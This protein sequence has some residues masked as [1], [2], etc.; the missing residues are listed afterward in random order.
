VSASFASIEWLPDPGRTPDELLYALDGWAERRELAAAT[1]SRETLGVAL[2]IAREKLAELEAMVAKEDASAAAVARDRYASAIAEAGTAV[3]RGEDREVA[4]LARDLCQALLEHQYILS[5]DY[6]TMP[7]AA[8]A[9]LADVVA[10]AER[11]YRE[12]A[13]RLGR[14]DRDAFFFKEGEVRWSVRAGIRD[15]DSLERSVPD[16]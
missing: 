7:S 14:A 6:E 9:I 2:R 13:P 11:A 8:R 15:D 3:T 4:A 12:V 10:D 1:T 5:V 16:R